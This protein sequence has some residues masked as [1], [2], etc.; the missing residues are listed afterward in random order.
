MARFDSGGRTDILLRIGGDTQRTQLEDMEQ[1]A[2][3]E[4][5]ASKRRGREKVHGTMS[6]SQEQG[7]TYL[8]HMRTQRSNRQ[9][10][11]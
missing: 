4:E 9:D 6:N 10:V 1:T 3:N 2:I 11:N 8:H 5:E 7:S